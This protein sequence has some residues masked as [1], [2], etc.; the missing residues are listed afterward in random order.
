MMRLF[1][2]ILVGLVG[3]SAGAG[4]Q[5]EWKSFTVPEFGLTVEF[6]GEPRRA[7]GNYRSVLT[8]GTRT[9]IFQLGTADAIYT[10]T[11]VDL[12]DRAEEAANF[13]QEAAFLILQSGSEVTAD[14]PVQISERNRPIYGRFIAMAFRHGP[15][16]DADGVTIPTS[17][18]LQWLANATRVN[19]ANGYSSATSLFSTRG[20]LYIVQGVSRNAAAAADAARFARSIKLAFEN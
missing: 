2:I 3:L 16:P 4:A 1:V 10:A 5:Q 7:V 17:S 15:T 12:A 18:A 8:R 6:P 9:H 13:M 11:V 19:M 20:R 14:E